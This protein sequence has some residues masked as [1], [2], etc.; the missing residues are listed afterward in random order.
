[1]T[2]I[3]FLIYHFYTSE[4]SA[5]LKTVFCSFVLFC[6]QDL[7]CSHNPLSLGAGAG[8]RCECL[9]PRTEQSQPPVPRGEELM[10]NSHSTDFFGVTYIF[11][12]IES[13]TPFER[14]WCSLYESLPE[15]YGKFVAK[16][17]FLLPVIFPFLLLYLF[18]F[19]YVTFHQLSPCY[20]LFFLPL[21]TTRTYF[22]FP[23]SRYRA[24]FY[25]FSKKF[26]M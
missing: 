2:F 5:M 3:I 16:L 8:P 26:L 25:H 22:T 11:D 9:L 24:N 13:A 19:F 20:L 23:T 7:W 17:F 21:T 6:F 14:T 15:F 10:V 12:S 18:F 1:M 4:K